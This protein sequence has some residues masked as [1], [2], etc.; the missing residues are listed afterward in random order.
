M[1]CLDTEKQGRL[2]LQHHLTYPDCCNQGKPAAHT[3]ATQT[4]S[5]CPLRESWSLMVE[6][7]SVILG[8]LA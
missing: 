4:R 1:C 5:H 6:R 7:A 8:R 2:F 3:L